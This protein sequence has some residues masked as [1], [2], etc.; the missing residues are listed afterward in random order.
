MLL[1]GHNVSQS[2][3]LCVCVCVCVRVCV[4]GCECVCVVVCV[5]CIVPPTHL[6]G[7]P[8]RVQHSVQEESHLRDAYLP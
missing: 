8:S 7:L 3:T 1:R 2:K 4:C 5:V 6:P